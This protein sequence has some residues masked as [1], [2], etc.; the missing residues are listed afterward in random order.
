[1]WFGANGAAWTE[2]IGYRDAWHRALINL[3]GVV[4]DSFF[5]GR[6]YDD[7]ADMREA[8]EAILTFWPAA[9]LDRILDA[10]EVEALHLVRTN[11]AAVE[12]LATEFMAAPS[13]ELVE[14]EIEAVVERFR[15]FPLVADAPLPTG[16]YLG[17]TRARV[18]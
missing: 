12:A 6:H 13:G 2:T 16:G 15:P 4:A 10:A 14:H 7:S 8:A 5:D 17:A 9:D 3:A 1:M 11:K 18:A